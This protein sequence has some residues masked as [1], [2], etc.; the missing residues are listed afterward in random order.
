M[1]TQSKKEVLCYVHENCGL[2]KCLDNSYVCYLTVFCKCV[3]NYLAAPATTAPQ[4]I[5]PFTPSIPLLL[6]IQAVSRVFVIVF[7]SYFLP[8]VVDR[9]LYLFLL[10]F[11][12]LLSSFLP[13]DIYLLFLKLGLRCYNAPYT[14]QFWKL[15]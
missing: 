6:I 9:L 7:A 14:T 3:C 10:F 13:G 11:Y 8:I 1:Y 15:Y 12:I 4:N 2:V 5:F